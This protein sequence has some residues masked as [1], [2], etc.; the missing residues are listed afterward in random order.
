MKNNDGVFRGFT[1]LSRCWY[2]NANLKNTDL[3]DDVTFGFYHEEGGCSGEM[4]MRWK[5]LSGA[6]IPYLK[7]YDDGWSALNEFKDILPHLADVDDLNIPP[8]DFCQILLDC[9]F[10]D[11]TKENNIN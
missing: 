5:E 9:G 8:E 7:V 2:A 4:S 1:Q 11:M 3:I 10:K 6:I